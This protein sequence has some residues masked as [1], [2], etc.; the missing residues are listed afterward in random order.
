MAHV[1][2]IVYLLAFGAGIASITASLLLYIRYRR[3]V[4]F[5][6]ALMQGVMFFLMLNRMA[7]TYLSITN[8]VASG[9]AGIAVIAIKKIAFMLGMFAGPAFAHHLV[10]VKM[11]PARKKA[12]CG[13]GFLYAGS[14][15]FELALSGNDA[16]RILG[17]WV[18]LPLLFGT[19]A[20]CMLLGGRRLGMLGNRTLENALKV[21]FAMALVGFPIAILQY[22]H[23]KSY[24]PHYLENPLMFFAVSLLSLI[25]AVR[26]FDQP[27]FL[28]RGSVTDAFRSRFSITDRE[29]DVV[30]AL[31]EGL[32]NNQIAERL[33]LS[34][35]TIESHLYNIF[36]KTNVKNRI[37]LV[38]L[39]L[40]NQRE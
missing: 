17:S 36:Q 18:G 26:Y 4:I 33:F 37:Q 32:S 9:M 1:S 16:S 19:M 25:F 21:F 3:R 40:T 30:K 24:M 35:R 6:Y 2:I 27:A 31:I 28:E 8:I 10:G 13:L 38:N 39:L 15:V 22:I 11:S 5:W 12:Y 7:E 23:P 20:W 29:S 14:V 34:P